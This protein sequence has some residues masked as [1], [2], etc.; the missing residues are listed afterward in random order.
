[1]TTTGT[2]VANPLPA[3][4]PQP[5]ALPMPSQTDKT[6]AQIRAELLTTFS[7]ANEVSYSHLMAGCAIQTHRTR[8]RS[9]TTRQI[10]SSDSDGRLHSSEQL[11]RNAPLVQSF[12]RG[13]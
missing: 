1:M 7:A 11:R 8:W 3:I 2:P 13:G 5:D 10:S 4:D 6:L 12:F 9:E